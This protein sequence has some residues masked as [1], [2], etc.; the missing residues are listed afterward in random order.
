MLAAPPPVSLVTNTVAYSFS[1]PAASHMLELYS[2]PKVNEV[3]NL[4][5]VSVSNKI[6]K[7]RTY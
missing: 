6:I 2:F 5:E 4:S 3:L 1:L 7:A